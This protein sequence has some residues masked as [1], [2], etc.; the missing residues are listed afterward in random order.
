MKKRKPYLMYAAVLLLVLA[1]IAN[2][3]S[4]FGQKSADKKALEEQQKKLKQQIAYNQK[5][6]DEARKNKKSSLAEINLLNAQIKK[7]TALLRTIESE[8]GYLSQQLELHTRTVEQLTLEI[9]RLKTSYSKAILL[10][11]KMRESDDRILYILASENLNQAWK[12]MRFLQRIASGRKDLFVQLNT[13]LEKQILTGRMIRNQLNEKQ[14]LKDHKERESLG[15][16]VEKEKKNQALSRIQKQEHQ[17]V[18]EI[19]RQKKEAAALDARISQI[20][21]QEISKSATKKTETTPKA[22]EAV[23]VDTRLSGSFA[24][25]KGKLPWPVEKGTISGTFGTHKHPDFDVYTENNGIDFLTNAGSQARAVFEGEV[26]EVIQLPSYYAVLIR[27]GEY[28]TLYSKLQSVFVRKGEK[29]ETGHLIG[30]IRTGE[31]GTEFHFEI[32]QGRTKQNPQAW[33]R[34]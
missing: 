32:W 14:M 25:N 12:R 31:A 11:Y 8:M 29:V 7:R 18:A 34:R 20:I 17:I 13:S 6:L 24:S 1:V 30:L 23:V 16:T 27:H 3:W 4:A 33:L 22:K 21:Q 9:N 28:F 15:L 19:N 10:S 2:G 5:L 26:S